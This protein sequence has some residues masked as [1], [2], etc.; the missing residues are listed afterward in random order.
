[1]AASVK[2]GQGQFALLAPSEPLISL[3]GQTLPAVARSP[4]HTH[5]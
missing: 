4:T 1:M 3:G 2:A 5:D